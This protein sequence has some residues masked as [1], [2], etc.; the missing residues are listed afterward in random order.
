MIESK[1][2][3]TFHAPLR[4]ITWLKIVSFVLEVRSGGA[5]SA[6]VHAFSVRF[7]AALL[8]H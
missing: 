4:K 1:K 7:D 6:A 8:F 2:P 5:V 3:L